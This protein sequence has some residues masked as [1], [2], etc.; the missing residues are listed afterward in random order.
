MSCRSD[1][2]PVS[3]KSRMMAVSRR[4][5]KLEPAAVAN[6]R[7]ICSSAM[8]GTG[9][10]VTLGRPH[11]LHRRL[12]DVAEVDEEHEEL[13]HSGIRSHH[14][15]AMAALCDRERSVPTPNV[16][17]QSRFHAPVAQSG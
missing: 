14:L 8:T 9:V 1:L 13:L 7:R 10:S 12:D 5:S 17:G 4:S 16:T 15:S 2:I 6:S 3:M 11:P